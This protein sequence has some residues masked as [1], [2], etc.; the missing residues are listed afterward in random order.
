MVYLQFQGPVSYFPSEVTDEGNGDS[1]ATA[2]PNS[3]SGGGRCGHHGG[4]G[5]G[6]A[7]GPHGSGGGGLLR[8]DDCN[9]REARYNGAVLG[10]RI[11]VM[12][13][14][15]VVTAGIATFGMDLKRRQQ[16]DFERN[17]NN[18][19][20][21]ISHSVWLK[22]STSLGIIDALAASVVSVTSP[23][24]ANQT[25][26]YVTVPNFDVLASKVMAL[27][28]LLFVALHPLVEEDQLAKFS[29]WSLDHEDEWTV[30]TLATQRLDP[31]LADRR[32]R[33]NHNNNG[34][35]HCFNANNPNNTAN[36]GKSNNPQNN[37]TTTF[38]WASVN[39]TWYV[40]KK[41]EREMR[42]CVFAFALLM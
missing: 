27:A 9:R 6:G 34:I 32:A 4:P 33:Y 1:T 21:K 18:E 31:N 23:A 19:A 26:P 39:T 10:L 11:A 40:P 7:G 16:R 17:F 12:L 22:A 14:I 30:P 41:E 25:W 2:D 3:S 42:C 36:G 5:T 8:H 28:P 35:N 29:A 13:A 20:Q 24:A 37:A 15:V 38:D